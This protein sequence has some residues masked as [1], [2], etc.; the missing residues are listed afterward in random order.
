MAL[1]GAAS[2]TDTV[3]STVT[4]I[5]LGFGINESPINITSTGVISINDSVFQRRLTGCAGG[6]AAQ[7]FA[8]NGVTTCTPLPSGVFINVSL[9]CDVDLV[10]LTKKYQNFTYTNGYLESNT[11]CI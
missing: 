10:G 9:V 2:L 7:N 5:T 8:Q 1:L 11:S 6:Y 3:A 4:L